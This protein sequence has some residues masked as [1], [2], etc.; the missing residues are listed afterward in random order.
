MDIT[1]VR[2][3]KI[4]VSDLAKSREWY[5]QVF[6]LEHDTSFQ[7]QDGV[8]RGMSFRVP[9]ASLQ[10][11]L[12]ENPKLAEALYDADPFALAVT[13]EALDAWEAYLDRLQIPHSSIIATG[14]GHAL[15]FRDPDGMQI[16]L[17][18]HDEEIRAARG[19]LVDSGR[20][21]PDETD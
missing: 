12:R 10:I 2:H 13:R 4:F 1:G 20:I 17:Y 8:V 9:G 19:D 11:A 18:A 7:D 6:R 21:G 3:L 14:S 5:E 16:R 15:G